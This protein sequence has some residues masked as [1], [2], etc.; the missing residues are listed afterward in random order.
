MTQKWLDEYREHVAEAKLIA[1]PDVRKQRLAELEAERISQ[2][3]I[4]QAHMADR[5]KLL[6]SDV[7]ELKECQTECRNSQKIKEAEKR[8]FKAGIRWLGGTLL[9]VGGAVGWEAVGGILKAF[10]A[11]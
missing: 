2:T 3:L 5:I 8:G 6:V 4:C 11:K 10:F 1:D 9:V 7:K